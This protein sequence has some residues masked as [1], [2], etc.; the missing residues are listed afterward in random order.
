MRDL[1]ASESPVDRFET[2]LQ[3]CGCFEQVGMFLQ[4]RI[5]MGFELSQ[6][7]L[8]MPGCH[9]TVTA[10]WLGH[11]MQ[12]VLVMPLQVTFYSADM[13]GEVL[14]GFPRGCAIQHQ[15]DNSS[16]KLQPVPTYPRSIHRAIMTNAL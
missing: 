1:V 8:L 6:Q 11:D 10:R 3:P 12:G 5:A 15:S 4:G 9:P 14:R 13:D 16:P 2:H 7:L